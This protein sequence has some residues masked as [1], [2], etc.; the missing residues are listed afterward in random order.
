MYICNSG[1]QLDIYHFRIRLISGIE[2]IKKVS[3]TTQW[4]PYIDYLYLNLD[5]FEND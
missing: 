1:V 2:S 5:I 4:R 3:H